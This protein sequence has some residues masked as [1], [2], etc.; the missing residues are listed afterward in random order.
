MSTTSSFS[1][2]SRLSR[3]FAFSSSLIRLDAEAVFSGPYWF[4]HP[5][6]V[7]DLKL[8]DDLNIG[9]RSLSILCPWRTFGR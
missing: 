5:Y 4:S 8:L 3:A 2:S 9:R 1:A 6:Q 7:G